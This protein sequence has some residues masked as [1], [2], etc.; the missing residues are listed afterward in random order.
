DRAAFV[1]ILADVV[2]EKSWILHAWVLMT[3][4]IHLVVSTPLSNLSDGMRELLRA[5]SARFNE[6]H[7]LTG[8][9]FHHR[10][11]SKLV[12]RERHLL[13]LI[14]YVPLNPVRCGLVRSPADWRWSSYPATAGLEPPVDWLECDWTLAQFHPTDR[15]LA[16]RR[17]REFVSAARDVEYDPHVDG[18]W[19]IGSPEFR[20][21]V[22]EWIDKA[23]GSEEQP[24]R[25]KR[26]TYA[27]VP[28]LLDHIRGRLG[29]TDCDLLRKQRGPARK[30][31]ADLAHTEC[32]KTFREIGAI[33]G[34]TA[35]AAAK[36]SARSRELTLSD[37]E[38]AELLEDIRV[39]LNFR[40]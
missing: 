4:H 2:I 15:H 5:Y 22:Q 18:D 8:N 28:S 32:G 34:V 10:F 30:L 31:L 36:L 3:N 14:R 1:R 29:L 20:R 39:K 11:R 19:I 35:A 7:G 24:Q 26:V 21:T 27:G 9:L 40:T 6:V 25:R 33:L 38:Y 16:Q 17:F 23:P 13:E 12:E 37:P